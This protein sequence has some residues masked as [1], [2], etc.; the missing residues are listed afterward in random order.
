MSTLK[1]IATRGRGKVPPIKFAVAEHRWLA[2]G[3]HA[4]YVAM[5]EVAD[6][7]RVR[8]MPA[9]HPI[10]KALARQDAALRAVVKAFDL[11]YH[12]DISDDEFRQHG[13]LYR[14]GAYEPSLRVARPKQ[15]S[16]RR[17][18]QPAPQEA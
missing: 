11:Q 9:S 17:T 18:R 4:A 10:A 3:L 15:L 7:V 8:G 2:G 14:R 6:A 1:N 5:T 13:Q 12:G 16:K